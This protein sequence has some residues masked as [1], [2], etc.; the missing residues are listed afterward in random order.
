MPVPGVLWEIW[1]IVGIFGNFVGAV[2]MQSVPKEA[3]M[4]EL[5]SEGVPG[6]A[7]PG[8]GSR[9]AMQ[10]PAFAIKGGSGVQDCGT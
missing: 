8:C 2:C 5:R 9:G 10:I 4:R 7:S 1:E 6:E 3:T